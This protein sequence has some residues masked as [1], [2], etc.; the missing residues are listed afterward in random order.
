MPRTRYELGTYRAKSE[1]L[2]VKPTR[3]IRLDTHVRLAGG[4]EGGVGA[5]ED[6]PLEGCCMLTFELIIR[7]VPSACD[8]V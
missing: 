7:V 2:S 4:G 8:I 1:T 6:S 3:Q 5:E